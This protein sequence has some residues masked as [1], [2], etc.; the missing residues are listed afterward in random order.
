MSG[1]LVTSEGKHPSAC[2]VD[3]VPGATLIKGILSEEECQRFIKVS[4][5]EGGGYDNAT[6]P[7]YQNEKLDKL[8]LRTRKNDRHVTRVPPDVEKSL[9]DLLEPF[10]QKTIEAEKYGT[11]QYWGL[12]DM[13]RFYRYSGA[14]QYFPVHR[15]N[16]TVKTR[17]FV[18]WMTVLVYL[19]TSG[20]GG[21]GETAFFPDPYS[22]FANKVT[23]VAGSA[24]VFH[25]TGE[26]SAWHCG[27]P[28]LVGESPN[29]V[30]K[31][32]LRTDVMYKAVEK[33]AQCLPISAPYN[34]YSDSDDEYVLPR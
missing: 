34:D 6:H 31:Y 30:K 5:E 33:P 22:S 28:L 27:L 1:Y 11:W 32:V 21:G 13:F 7:E 25:H 29:D 19:T 10:C 16:T 17:E 14:E 4:E 24:L 23:P 2:E 20:E 15:D 18:S 8:E 26:K 9:S 3:D 12:N